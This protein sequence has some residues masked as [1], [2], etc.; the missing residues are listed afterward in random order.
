MTINPALLHKYNVPVPRYTSYPTVPF[1]HDHIDIQQWTTA[2]GQQFHAQNQRRGIS[3]YIHLPFCESLCT[4]CGCNKKITTNHSVEGEYLQA[5]ITEWTIYR[6]LM[7]EAP[8]IREMHLGGGT[9]TFFSPHHLEQLINAITKDAIIHPEHEFSFEGHPNNTTQQHLETLYQLG[10]RRV[11][12]GVQDN[13][14]AIQRI[15]NR[16]QP[17][18][19]V[20]RVTEQARAIGF[21]AVNFDL[22]YGLPL[23]TIPSIQQSILRSLQLRPDRV[24]FYSYAHVPWTSRG[25]RLFDENDLP[26]AALKMQLYQ[27]GRQL[28][29]DH[30]YTDIGMDHFALPGDALHTAWQ[31]NTLHRNFM[32]Y[33]TQHSGLLLGLGVSAISDVG[34]AFA[35]NNKTLHD[36]YASLAASVASHYAEHKENPAEHDLRNASLEPVLLPVVKGYFLSKEDEA[37]RKYIMEVIC[38]GATVFQPEHLPLLRQYTFPELALLAADQLVEWNEEGVQVTEGGRHFLRNICKAFDL[39]LLRREATSEKPLFS[40]A[41]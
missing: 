3:L 21:T 20:Q 26:S 17:F 30:G 39:H 33:T 18:E 8:V 4:Y 24:A 6:R 13:D 23:Q 37:F 14:P 29:I 36:Y 34:V 27:T 22:I 35:Q 9:P 7:G 2:F 25:Q 15:I 16:I 12:F 10:F 31:Q 19:N 32:G 1:W 40:K 38:R 11:S 5:I 28:F 41:I